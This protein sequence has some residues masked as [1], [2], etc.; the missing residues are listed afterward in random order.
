MKCPICGGNILR[1]YE[2]DKSEKFL[3]YMCDSCGEEFADSGQLNEL[4]NKLTNK[5]KL[6]Q[7][8]VAEFNMKIKSLATKKFLSEGRKRKKNV[9]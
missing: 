3:V 1:I 5:S 9:N 8:D 6:S 4:A 7:K 2:S